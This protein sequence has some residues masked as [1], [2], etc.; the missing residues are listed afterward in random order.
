MKLR[1]S[2]VSR[3]TFLNTLL[4]GWFFC[5]FLRLFL[6][7]S[8]WNAMFNINLKIKSSTAPATSDVSMR[9]A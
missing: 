3:R 7:T 5:L 8:E 6:R 2:L 4:G 9:M 1:F